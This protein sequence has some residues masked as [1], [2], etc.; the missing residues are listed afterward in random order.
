MIKIIKEE[1]KKLSDQERAA[2]LQK[3]FKTGK[4]EYGEGDV[5]LGLRVPTIRNIAK[6]FNTLSMDEAEEF[7]QSP[8]HEERLFAIFVLIDLFEKAKEEDRKKIYIL[9]LKNTKF[10]NNWDLVDTSAGPIVGAYLFNG[11]KEPI[12]ILAKSENLWERRIAIMAT[13][14]FITQNEFNDTLKIAEM[15]LKDQEDLIHK[16]VGWM[17]RE[18]GKRNLELEESFLKKHYQNMPRTMLR[19]AIEKFPEEKRKSYLKR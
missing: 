19:Y 8:Y 16:A 3:Y 10:I 6:K 4:D 15:F 1:F 9:Y 12:Y 11:D 5:F 18:I 2:H 7:L 14:Y 13:F 17:L